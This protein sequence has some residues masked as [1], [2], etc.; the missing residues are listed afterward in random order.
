MMAETLAKKRILKKVRINSINKRPSLNA[1]ID[2]LPQQVQ[3]NSIQM[4]DPS[5]GLVVKNR[6]ICAGVRFLNSHFSINNLKVQKQVHGR[7]VCFNVELN[8][9]N[10][11]VPWEYHVKRLESYGNLDLVT[12]AQKIKGYRS[13]YPKVMAQYFE[14]VKSEDPHIM[15]GLAKARNQVKEAQN[16]IKSRFPYKTVSLFSDGV[17]TVPHTISYSE[18]LLNEMDHSLESFCDSVTQ[19]GIPTLFGGDSQYH[20]EMAKSFLTCSM[21]QADP[22]KYGPEFKSYLYDKAGA[23]RPAVFQAISFVEP[24]PGGLNLTGYLIIKSIGDQVKSYQEESFN[25]INFKPKCFKNGTVEDNI[26]A[27]ES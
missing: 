9:N 27:Q 22:V 14:M 24:A 26:L 23:K 21:L 7:E 1:E 8:K 11:I 19:R 5:I 10:P 12:W 2:L 20:I 17:A 6:K 25:D 18:D 3:E 4:I 13:T 16:L 15:A